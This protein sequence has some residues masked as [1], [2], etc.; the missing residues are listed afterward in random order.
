MEAKYAIQHTRTEPS[1][2][3]KSGVQFIQVPGTARYALICLEFGLS[4]RQRQR[5][6]QSA[7]F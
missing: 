2:A 4:R 5:S 3:S 1:K 6:K 7:W